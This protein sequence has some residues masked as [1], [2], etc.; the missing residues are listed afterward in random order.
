M[1]PPPATARVTPARVL[2]VEDEVHLRRFVRMALAAEGHQVTESATLARG[3]IDAGTWQPDLVV[4]DLG[5]PDGDGL[6]FIRAFRDWSIAP[7]LVLS[8]R[9][10]ETE[11]VKALDAGAD[12]YLTKPFGAAE[13]LA[14][15]RAHLR[16][17]C[18]PDTAADAVLRFGDVV[19]DRAHRRVYR[20]GLPVH[21]TPIEYRLLSLLT[22]H[23]DRVLTH[24]QLLLQTWGP[25]HL[26]QAHYLRVHLAN[27]RKKIEPD[28]ARP[29]WLRTETGVGYRF[30]SDEHQRG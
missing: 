6:Q 10:G 1:N 30:V 26:A 2:V 9:T 4:L 12:D 23:P 29:T 24:Q 18:R 19:L 7:V 28:P 21:L 3:L 8:A 5:L 16:R 25:Q 11:K 27:L 17:H 13:L 20:A 22:A 15:T 14:R